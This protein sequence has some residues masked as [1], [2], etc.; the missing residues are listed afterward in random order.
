V[1]GLLCTP[2]TQERIDTS[3]LVPPTFG[4]MLGWHD[5]VREV[6][7][8][9]SRIRPA[10]R[11]QTSILVDDYGEAASIDYYGAA[12]GLPPALSG[13]NQYWYWGLR[14]QSPRNMLVVQNSPGQPRPYSTATT[15]LGTTESLYAR[16]FENG[17]AIVYCR[18][19]KISLKREW[20]DERVLI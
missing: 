18:G 7:E 10:E 5:F 3:T 12:Y 2:R 19:L 4:D 1:K 6:A 20:T 16:S 17:K 14:G 15:L 8:A 9:W 11:A 13:H